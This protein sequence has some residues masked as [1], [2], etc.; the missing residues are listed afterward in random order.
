MAIAT[1]GYVNLADDATLTAS[2]AGTLTPAS[3]LQQFDVART[4]QGASGGT[5]YCV[6]DLGSAQSVNA[7]AVMG[8]V[9]DTIRVRLSSADASGAAGDLYDSGTVSVDQT[10]L[11]Y[12][13]YLANAVNARYARVDLVKSGADVEAGRLFVGTVTQFSANF[14]W[15]WHRGRVDRS[16]RSQT[17]GGQTVIRRRDNP[18]TLDVTFDFLTD[19]EAVGIVE[20]IDAAN[21]THTDVLLMADPE[22]ANLARDTIWG[23]VTELTPVTNPNFNINSK[24][25]KIEQR[26]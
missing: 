18:R 21:A 22:S 9:A 4:W 2:T 7:V 3:N 6:A 24:Q 19:A 5:D 23:L 10:Y 25:Y 13:V 16:I 15:G 26:L 12:V 14:S 11:Q 1:I 8:L 20:S 17:D